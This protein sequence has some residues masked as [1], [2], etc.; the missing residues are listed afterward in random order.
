VTFKIGDRVKWQSASAG[1]WK[2]K[3]GEVVAVLPPGA[4]PSR[5][6]LRNPGASRNHES[7]IVRVREGRSSRIYWPRVAALTAADEKVTP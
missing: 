2:T 4:D 5:A 1:T 7:Y 6:G 3:A